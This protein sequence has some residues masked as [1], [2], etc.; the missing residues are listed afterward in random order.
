MGQVSFGP[1][2]LLT[3]GSGTECVEPVLLPGKAVLPMFSQLGEHSSGLEHVTTLLTLSLL[4][5]ALV[6]D[7][8]GRQ[9]HLLGC[10]LFEV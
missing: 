4:L 2:I 10:F 5:F 7:F 8:D 9:S 1:C 3:L 6:T